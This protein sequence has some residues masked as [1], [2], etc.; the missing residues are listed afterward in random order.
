MK[1]WHQSIAGIAGT[2]ATIFTA[3]TP[4]LSF[5]C[6]LATAIITVPPAWEKLRGYVAKVIQYFNPPTA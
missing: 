5:V 6:A 4:A 3:A 2:T 1:N